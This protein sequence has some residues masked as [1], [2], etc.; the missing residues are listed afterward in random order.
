MKAQCLHTELLLQ[1]ELKKWKGKA[2][3]CAKMFGWLW[4]QAIECRRF[5]PGIIHTTEDPGMKPATAAIKACPQGQ[6][7][8]ASDTS[9]CSGI[10]DLPPFSFSA[11][12]SHVCKTSLE[13]AACSLYPLERKVKKWTM[14]EMLP[15]APGSHGAKIFGR[16]CSVRIKNICFAKPL[17]VL[18]MQC[19]KAF[20]NSLLTRHHE[21][22]SH[23]CTSLSNP[24]WEWSEKCTKGKQAWRLT[25]RAMSWWSSFELFLQIVFSL[26]KVVTKGIV[27]K[28]TANQFGTKK[29]KWLTF[30]LSTKSRVTIPSHIM[31]ATLHNEA[32]I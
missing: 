26:C 5:T 19:K 3:L 30:L 4:Y 25:A 27:V 31:Q 7:Q 12:L 22:L 16:L 20:K 18:E 17:H 14:L 8:V 21:A 15:I 28:P 29:L 24:L 6:V 23:I 2:C 32:R 13:W 9:F 1:Q 10:K 11:S